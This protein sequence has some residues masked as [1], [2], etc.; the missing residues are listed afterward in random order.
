MSIDYTNID[1]GVNKLVLKF[2]ADANV[3][4][5]PAT[6]LA[7]WNTLFGLPDI[8]KGFSFNAVTYDSTIVEVT[9]WGGFLNVLN[10]GLSTDTHLI[11]V[12]SNKGQ[13]FDALSNLSN[14]T[15]FNLPQALSFNSRCF[16]DCTSITKFSF[17]K[18]I[19]FDVQCFDG[20]DAATHFILPQGRYFGE[21][22]FADCEATEVL[23]LPKAE[24]LGTD[25]FDG[26]TGQDITLTIPAALE[27]DAN[28]VYLQANNNVTLIL[29]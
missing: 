2:D 5:S 28:V 20:C 8:L 29:T 25:C 6:D 13:Q 26:I 27:L 11:S 21:E 17:P 1:G 24:S 12:Y 7:A 3:P 9:L 23:Y 16:Q 10:D 4:V 19:N 14:A 15:S 18:G 22:C